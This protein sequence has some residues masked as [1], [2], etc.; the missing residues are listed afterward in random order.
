MTAVLT[1]GSAV[2]GQTFSNVEALNVSLVDGNTAASHALTMN[3]ITSPVDSVTLTGTSATGAPDELSLTNLAL[4]TSLKMSGVANQSLTVG[5]SGATGSSDSASLSLNGVTSTAGADTVVD[6]AAIEVLNIDVVSNSVIGTLTTTGTGTLN[7]TGAGN[8]GVTNGL[9]ATI[10]TVAAGDATGNLSITA[11][12]VTDNTNPSTVDVADISITTGSGDDT[13][14]VNAVNTARELAISTGAGDDTVVMDEVVAAATTTLAGDVIDGGDGTDI[15]SMDDT[16]AQAQAATTTVSNFEELT[17]SDALS[18]GGVTVA[19]LQAGLTTVNLAA[20]GTG[21]L[22]MEAGS[23]TVN[24]QNVLTGALTVVDTGTGTSDSASIVNED[25]AANAFAGQNLVSTGYETVNIVTT[26]T[27]AATAQTI[28]TIGVTPDT[29]GSSVVNFSGSNAVTTGAITAGTVSAAGLTGTAT[30]TMGAA[31]VG[32][33]TNTVT[34]SAN[35][36]TLVGDANDTTNID[37]GAGDDDI[38]GGTDAETIQG[39][40]GDDAI[41]GGGGAD[42]I[43]GGDGDDTI[44]LG[45]TA[46]SVHGDAGDDT[47]IAAGN[48]TFGTS[49]TDGEG[50]DTLSVNDAVTLA[51]GS[52]TSGFEK[53]EIAV[54]AADTTVDLD[55]LG[56]NTFTDV[57][58]KDNSEAVTITSMTDQAVT[59]GVVLGDDL[60]LTKESASGSSDSQT[61]T[62][63]SAAGLTQ[64]SDIVVA[65][66]EAI[67]LASNDTNTTAH[68]NTVLLTV[69]AATSLTITGNTGVD[70]TGSGDLTALFDLNASGVVL[71][72]VTATGLTYAAT[73]NQVGGVTTIVGTNGVDDLTGAANTA[74]AIDG[75]SGADTLVYTGGADTFTGGAGVDT[76]DINAISTTSGLTITD[77]ADSDIIDL[78]GLLGTA[79]N[80][81]YTAAEFKATKVTLGSAATLANYLDAAASDNG[82]ATGD[83]ELAWFTFGGDTYIVVDNNDATVFTASTDSV[84]KLA[85]SVEIA[86]SSVTDGVLTLG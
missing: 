30:L 69:A 85:G 34:G 81:D 60:T 48:L 11:G 16:D 4:N 9:G 6:I 15:I 32:G 1:A 86:D 38:T 28:G 58:I 3:M 49:V 35:D 46:E 82:A 21:S 40:A 55:N 52:A 59:V 74:D 77:A 51:E 25:A 63:S 5:Y 37:G 17:I 66:V 41:A 80:V 57:I 65:G 76:H 36:D 73:Y 67:T 13:V 22:T 71:G 27:G 18:A 56:T 43:N 10:D 53:L 29:G 26:G 2:S 78:A 23:V 70:L 8:F 72:A 7:I 54:I 39:G 33:T 45:G 50:I 68:V 84:I 31:L 62:L 61:I 14:N 64:T 83:E 19:N 12:N 20:G 47:I 79:A 42:T 75:G 24:L 44:T